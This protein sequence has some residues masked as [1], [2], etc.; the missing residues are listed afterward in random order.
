VHLRNISAKITFD[1]DA[2]SIKL[3]KLSTDQRTTLFGLL[4]VADEAEAIN[5]ISAP[6]IKSYED[7]NLQTITLADNTKTTIPS[8][9][10][11]Q[12]AQTYCHAMMLRNG[13]ETVIELLPDATVT[14]GTYNVKDPLLMQSIILVCKMNNWAC[15][16]P[17]VNGVKVNV[18]DYVNIDAILSAEGKF[19]KRVNLPSDPATPSPAAPAA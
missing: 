1:A 15:R 16:K 18:P 13:P 19:P 6:I 14:G 2:K 9:A 8:L 7:A 3:D 17:V 4:N 5:K 12:F 11:L 10:Y